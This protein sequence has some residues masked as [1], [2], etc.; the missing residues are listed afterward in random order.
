MALIDQGPSNVGKT[1]LAFDLEERNVP[2]MQTD[3]LLGGVLQRQALRLVAG[4]PR[5]SRRCRG[6]PANLAVIGR[7]VA[8]ECPREFVDLLLLRGADR[9][10][11]LLHRGRD[12]APPRDREGAARRLEASNIR[13]WFV[14]AS[15]PASL[16]PADRRAG[17]LPPPREVDLGE[18]ADHPVAVVVE[19]RHLDVEPR[20]GRDQLG[21]VVA[22]VEGDERARVA[23]RVAVVLGLREVVDA[24]VRP[25]ERPPLGREP[26][27]VGR[28]R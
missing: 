4:R 19:A 3:R 12:P 14:S 25:V 20:P 22:V 23:D 10:G 9:G 17:L 11:P 21:E 27:L 18:L 26:L 15:R 6:A 8:A 13:P 1:T 16:A 2:L 7:E 28:A 5:W 24:A